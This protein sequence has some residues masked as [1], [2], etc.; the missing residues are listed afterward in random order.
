MRM[1]KQGLIL[2]VCLLLSVG[3]QARNVEVGIY[4]PHSL[5][6]VLVKPASGSYE[7]YAGE[8]KILELESNVLVT[9]SLRN[10]LVAVSI[11]GTEL[12]EFP[13]LKLS[14]RSAESTLRVKP[15][16]PSLKESI[17][18]DSFEITGARGALRM[19]NKVK[20]DNYIAGVLESEI[21]MNRNIEFLKVQAIIC[22]TYAVSNIKRHSSE[23]YDLCDQVHCQA[24]KGKSRLNLLISLAVSSTSA[25]LL[26]DRS[27]KPIISAFHSNCGGQTYNSEDIWP[28]EVSY[29]RSVRDSFCAGS[30]HAI[31][32]HC[33]PVKD[34]VSYLGSYD[35]TGLLKKDTAARDFRFEAGKK[36]PF[37]IYKG[38]VVPVKDIRRDWKLRSSYFSIRQ[39][40]DTLYFEGR[41]YGHGIGMCQEGAMK[42]AALGYKHTE[43]INFYYKG[44]TITDIHNQGLFKE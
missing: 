39:Q 27:G 41:G 20:L 7:M 5:T 34:W 40:Q 10:G 13:E 30:P 35:K 3:M 42:M 8:K 28:S 14:A 33:I 29:L 9:L 37:Y 31:W 25:Q 44:V 4:T 12:G 21:G 43:I 32:R 19:V 22:R 2:L 16:Q 38:V 24:Y 23:G 6:S 11:G 17:Y 15:L 1:A 36:Q 26:T 18:D